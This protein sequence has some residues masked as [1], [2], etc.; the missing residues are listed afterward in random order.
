[1]AKDRDFLLK[2][3]V[4]SAERIPQLYLLAIELLMAF[5]NHVEKEIEKKKKFTGN[6]SPVAFGNEL[7]FPNNQVLA[8]LRDSD[9]Y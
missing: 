2:N 7:N 9:S 4:V 1:N 8:T 5:A 6:S 3:M